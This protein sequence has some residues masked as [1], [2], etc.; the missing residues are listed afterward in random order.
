M[1]M[2]QHRQE[3]PARG[4]RSTRIRVRV[5]QS[6]AEVQEPLAVTPGC[7]FLEHGSTLFP[8][9]EP[10]VHLIV[11]C[12]GDSTGGLAAFTPTGADIRV[13][14]ELWWTRACRS[15]WRRSR[16]HLSGARIDGRGGR[17][18]ATVCAHGP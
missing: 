7:S 16:G 15:A 2:N 3:Q 17:M 1:D 10:P 14:G 11:A 13:A 8:R 12:D 4:C 6:P 9:P 5:V 18:C